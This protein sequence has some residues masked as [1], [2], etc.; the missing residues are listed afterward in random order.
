MQPEFAHV[1]MQTLIATAAAAL[2]GSTTAQPLPVPPAAASAQFVVRSAAG[3]IDA[4]NSSGRAVVLSAPAGPVVAAQPT[5]AVAPAA[6]P[7]HAPQEA[8]LQSHGPERA[9]GVP[10]AVSKKSLGP[11]C[12]TFV[13]NCIF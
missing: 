7:D 13:E 6:A 2:A 11:F 10:F 5:T 8:A 3:S 1:S 4:P 12:L 9:F